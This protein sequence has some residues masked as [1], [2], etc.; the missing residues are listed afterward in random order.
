MGIL[1][2]GESYGK[3]RLEA[4]CDRANRI[5]GT[6][7]KSVA[8]ILKHGLDQRPPAVADQERPAVLHANI[9]GSQYYH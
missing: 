3:D 7:Y 1:R 2:P 5:G 9:R 6:S 8:S 4:A